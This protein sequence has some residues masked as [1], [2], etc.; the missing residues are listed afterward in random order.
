MARSILAV[1]G[2]LR[3]QSTN[4]RLLLEVGRYAGAGF[5]FELFDQLEALPHYNPDREDQLTRVTELWIN[6]V[7]EAEVVIFASPEYAH[8]IPGAFKN[9]LDWLVGTDAFIN[10]PYT[11]YCACPRPVHCP[12]QLLEVLNT[13]SG[14]HVQEAD[15][16]IDMQRNFEIADHVLARPDSIERIRASLALLKDYQV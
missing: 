5:S 10:K 13:M 8:G 11:L 6:K 9:A 14:V 16:T 7:K 4:S 15:V 12:A 3:K 2:S 1:S